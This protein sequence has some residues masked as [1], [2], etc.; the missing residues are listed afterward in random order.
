MLNT[1]LGWTLLALML[2]TAISV[3]GCTRAGGADAYREGEYYDLNGALIELDEPL[4]AA[5]QIYMQAAKE[6]L[7]SLVQQ[8][9]DKAYSLLGQHATQRMSLNQF[10]PPDDEAEAERNDRHP[11]INVSEG[12]FV[13]QVRAAVAVFGTPSAATDLYIQ[14][15]DPEVLSGRG[16]SLDVMFS[17]GGM[18]D[19]VPTDIRRASLRGTIQTKLTASEAAKIARDYEIT[20]DEVLSDEDFAPYFTVKIVLV[21]EQQ[22]LKVG[23]FEFLPP[24]IFD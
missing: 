1:L 21:E 23:Y 15:M 22:T 5:E 18:P 17:I 13:Q 14:S 4:T 24:S 6:F 19:T 9:Y 12:R 2:V 11:L 20:V 8:Q 16:D 3:A 10:Q 7:V